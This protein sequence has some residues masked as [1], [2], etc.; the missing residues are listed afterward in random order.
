[1]VLETEQK[2]YDSIKHNLLK[3]HEGKF[4]LIIAEDML[5]AFDNPVDAYKVGLQERGNVPMLIKHVLR[6]EPTEE[7]PALSLGLLSARL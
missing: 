7:I 4:V 2:H 5:G 6:E 1:M 3:H